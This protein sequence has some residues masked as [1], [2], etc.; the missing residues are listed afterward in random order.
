MKPNISDWEPELDAEENFELGFNQGYAKCRADVE[1][2]V[3]RKVKE[4]RIIHKKF[5]MDLE[6]PI[7]SANLVIRNFEEL[8]QEI[9][10]LHSQQDNTQRSGAHILGED[11][12]DANAKGEG[13]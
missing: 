12:A 6:A 8:K 5:R 11:I 9:A 7:H 10:R 2:I 3:D 13:K 1:K 4:I